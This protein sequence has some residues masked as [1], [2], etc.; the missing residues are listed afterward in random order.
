MSSRQDR[1]PWS[2]VTNHVVLDLEAFDSTIRAA[3]AIHRGTTGEDNL[4]DVIIKVA[5]DEADDEDL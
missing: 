1:D 5:G 4:F 2:L 3:I